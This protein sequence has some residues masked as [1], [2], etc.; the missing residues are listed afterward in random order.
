MRV[1]VGFDVHRLGA[2]RPLRLGGVE[3]A[4]SP[5]LIGHSDADCVLHAIT[6]A[7]LGAAGLGDIGQHFPDDDPQY[8][9]ADSKDLLARAV[10]FVADAGWGP[11]S[12]DCTVLAEGPKLA[13]YRDEMRRT[14]AAAV[15]L[16]E[17]AVGVK[18]TTLEG[19]GALGR[20]EG[21]ACHAVC[22]LEER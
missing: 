22:L 8:K 3:I 19:L 20:G 16:T 12:V 2:A 4:G 11:V 1:G 18:F 14:I 7:L 17:D 9:D 5:G 6:D 15:G 10:G 21:I 13:P